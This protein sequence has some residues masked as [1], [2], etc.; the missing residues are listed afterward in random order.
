MGLLPICSF[1][2]AYQW[3]PAAN[4]A[5]IGVVCIHDVEQILEAAGIAAT[6]RNIP[7]SVSNILADRRLGLSVSVAPFTVL[8]PGSPTVLST[9]STVLSTGLF[10]KGVV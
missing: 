9:L 6:A 2:W 4:V 10:D 1:Q 8:F 7:N 5:A 3:F